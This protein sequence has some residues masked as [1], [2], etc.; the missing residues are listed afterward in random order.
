M[1]IFVVEPTLS[2]IH[3]LNRA[4]DLLKHFEI[5]PQVIVNKYDLNETNTNDIDDYCKDKNIEVL[6]HVPFDP[7]VTESMVSGT[8]IVEYSPSQPASKAII[9]IWKVLSDQLN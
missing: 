8:P 1:S 3:D 2:G 5:I 6:G 4:L 9:E 7:K